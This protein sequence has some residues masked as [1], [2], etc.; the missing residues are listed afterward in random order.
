MTFGARFTYKRT[1][2]LKDASNPSDPAARLSESVIAVLNA[3]H[4]LESSNEQ[5]R[6][7]LAAMKPFIDSLVAEI[8]ALQQWPLLNALWPM[9]ARY[10]AFEDCT[11][12]PVENSEHVPAETVDAGIYCHSILEFNGRSLDSHNPWHLHHSLREALERR[13]QASKPAK[14]DLPPAKKRRK[15]KAT[16][17]FED[18]LKQELDAH[19]TTGNSSSSPLTALHLPDHPPNVPPPSR[20]TVPLRHLHTETLNPIR[21]IKLKKC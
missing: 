2:N 5:M 7:A 10:T 20:L 16:L 17:T 1:V 21:W 18:L 14:A 15:K 4:E 6:I 11:V 8:I 13:D 9:L 12:A 3:M 19:S